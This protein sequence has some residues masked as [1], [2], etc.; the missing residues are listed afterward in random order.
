V[1]AL[2]DVY[3]GPY[4]DRLPDLAVL[5]DSSFRWNAVSSPHLGTLQVRQQDQRVGSHT[6]RSFLLASGPGVPRGAA[7]TGRSILDVAPTVLAAAG[8]AVRRRWTD[9]RWI[10]DAETTRVPLSIRDVQRR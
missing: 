7:V 6:P 10:S 9:V 3:H 4:V 1:T 5:W 8:V 2:H